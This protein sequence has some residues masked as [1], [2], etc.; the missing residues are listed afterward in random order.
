MPLGIMPWQV[1][2]EA[3]VIRLLA[4]MEAADNVRRTSLRWTFSSPQP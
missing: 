4:A 1:P 2:E 3:A